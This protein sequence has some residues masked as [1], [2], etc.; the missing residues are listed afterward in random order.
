MRKYAGREYEGADDGF[1]VPKW[2]FNRIQ[3]THITDESELIGNLFSGKCPTFL[4]GTMVLIC[5]DQIGN[6]KKGINYF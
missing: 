5:R 4:L 6:Y 2:V 3:S 1:E